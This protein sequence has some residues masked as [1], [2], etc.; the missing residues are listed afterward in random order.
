MHGVRVPRRRGKDRDEL[1]WAEDT[2]GVLARARCRVGGLR[3]VVGKAVMLD[4]I[5]NY[6]QSLQRQVEFLS[7]K[8]ATV[9]PQLDFNNLP[10]LLSKDVRTS[11][12]DHITTFC[13]FL[14]RLLHNSSY[15]TYQLCNQMQQSCGPLQNS[16]F[17]LETSGAPMTYINQPHQGNP[18]GCSLTNGMDN[19]SSMHPLDPAFCRS[20]N[21]QHPFLNGVSDSTSQVGTFWQDDLQS[22]V[23]M[24][25]GQSQEMATS[26]NSYNGSL[27][28]VHMKMEL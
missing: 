16:H 28:T 22:V 27:Q 1:R 26:S 24:D 13:S 21:S 12:Y 5:I 19:Q 14:L 7:M 15:L 17:P 8:L 20:M 6:V 4:E 10:N 3:E 25:M 18:L 2:S 11:I 23:H 9:N